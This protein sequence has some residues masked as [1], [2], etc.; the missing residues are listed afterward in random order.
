MTSAANDLVSLKEPRYGAV[1]FMS[2]NDTGIIHLGL[3]LLILRKE[4]IE[5]G[6]FGPIFTRNSNI[7][8]ESGHPYLTNS[9]IMSSKCHAPSLHCVE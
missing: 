9:G 5:Q 7:S 1:F 3:A 2:E 6:P 8:G 4:S